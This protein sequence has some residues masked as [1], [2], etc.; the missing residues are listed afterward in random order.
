MAYY[1]LRG[2]QQYGPYSLEDLRR[3]HAQGNL[4]ATDLVRS[5]ETAQWMPLMQVISAPA[6]M[7]PPPPIVPGMPTPPAVTP[8]YSKAPLPPNMHWALVLLLGL[9]TCGL[10]SWYWAFRQASWVK[11]IV[12]RCNA[13][14]MYAL[15]LIL[16]ALAMAVSVGQVIGG[17][18]SGGASAVS[19]LLQL[20]A[21][22][23]FWIGAFNI[24]SCLLEYYNQVEPISLRLS[25]IMTFFFTVLYFQHHMSRIHR[26]KTTGVL[27]PQG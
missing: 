22:A 7:L 18:P 11:S 16:L 4:V 2:Q 26:W 10:F 8:A 12:P 27:T 9:L 15:Y 25:A 23:C 13:I 5:E 14:L 19:W 21:L 20:G 17:S 3:Y 6:P 1:V 24:R